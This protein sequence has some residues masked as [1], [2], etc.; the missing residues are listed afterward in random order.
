VFVLGFAAA[1][2]LMAA[3]TGAE[4]DGMPQK[5]ATSQKVFCIL[6]ANRASDGKML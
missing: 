1:L 6:W 2:S 5:S 3:H 4:I